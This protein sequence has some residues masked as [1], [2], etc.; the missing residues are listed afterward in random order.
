MIKKFLII[1]VA[2]LTSFTGLSACGGGPGSCASAATLSSLTVVE[3]GGGGGGG[4]SGSHASSSG[5]SGARGSGSSA[6]FSGSRSGSSSGA[7]FSGS[8]TNVI[9]NRAGVHVN[10]QAPSSLGRSY[11]YGGHHYVYVYHP[12]SYWNYQPIDIYDPYDPR[13]WTNRFSPFYGYHLNV[14]NC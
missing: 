14:A 3:R 13:N 8:H 2:T 6:G 10:V 4:F 12:R 9:T 1:A 5:S 7:G 11:T